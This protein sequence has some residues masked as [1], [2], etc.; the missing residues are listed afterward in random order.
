MFLLEKFYEKVDRKIPDNRVGMVEPSDLRAVIKDLGFQLFSDLKS[1]TAGWSPVFAV[2]PDGERRV[3]K[4]VDWTGSLGTK[5]LTGLYVGETGL[6]ED[7]AQ[8]VDV[9]GVAGLDGMDGSDG[10][11][12]TPGAPGPK[13]WSPILAA[14]ADGTRRVMQVVDWVGGEGAKPATGQFLTPTGLTTVL[15]NALDMRGAPGADGVNGTPGALWFNGSGVP[16]T[17]TGSNGDYFLNTASGD[18]YRKQSGAW[19]LQ[20]NIR[21]PQGTSGTPGTN[22]TNG[23]TWFNSTGVPS[24][25]TGADGDYHLNTST[26]DVSRKAA[27]AWSVI[28]NIR[29]PQGTPGTN[30]TNGAT[31]FSGSGVPA[32]ATG[33]N[34]DHYLNTV[35]G[36]VYRRQSGAW[37]VVGNI[38]GADGVA[39]AA[40]YNG[41]G[42]PSNVTGVNG[43]YYLDTVSGDVYRKT[44][45]TWGIVGNIKGPGGGGGGATEPVT[46]SIGASGASTPTFTGTLTLIGFVTVTPGSITDRVKLSGW[47]RPRKD[48]GTTVRQYWIQCKRNLTGAA[49]ASSD[50]NIG[51]SDSG[52]FSLGTANSDMSVAPFDIT[53]APGVATPVTYSLWA[54]SDGSTLTARNY[55]INAQVLTG[56]SGGGSS[57]GPASVSVASASFTLAA[58]DGG[59]IIPVTASIPTVITVPANASVSIPAGTT[60]HLIQESTGFV[61]VNP[62]SGVTLRSRNDYRRTA[63]RGDRLTLTKIDTNVWDLSGDLAAPLDGFSLNMAY[64]FSMRRLFSGYSHK[65]L[66]IRRNGDNQETGV[67]FDSMGRISR[68]SPTESDRLTLAEWAGWS[69][70]FVKEFYNQARWSHYFGQYD[71]NM[72]PKM[73]FDASGRAMLRFDGQD[74]MG[75]GGGADFRFLHDGTGCFLRLKYSNAQTTLNGAAVRVLLSTTEGGYS[76][77]TGFAIRLNADNQRSIS[78]VRGSSGNLLA[79]RDAPATSG[80]EI[81]E[82]RHK[83]DQNPQAV[84]NLNGSIYSGAYSSA[85]PSSGDS[86]FG[87]FLGG[88]Y[89]FQASA[90]D[91]DELIIFREMLSDNQVIAT[92]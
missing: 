53:D 80:Y 15:A 50:P 89:W 40:W 75:M 27:G 61:V 2:V 70:V 69:D 73:V 81:A 41:T 88:P 91:F 54:R 42:A 32:S 4:L 79:Y 26:G 44:A 34:G 33:V 29:G 51:Q 52:G 31:W 66:H 30:G 48:G 20:G 59:K 38:R 16:A 67:F 24:A 72:Q 55:E 7:M 3:M 92:L 85:P 21:G 65:V 8:A 14:V 87:M 76:G 28:G 78:I 10:L 77:E 22:G 90:F 68:F 19:S 17:A 9:R 36:D 62:A 39:G 12:G 57:S 86:P 23:A 64:A 74:A 71:W 11:P 47:L 83:F 1:A 35:N 25:A 82:F 58:S 45:G 46:Q 60:V 63:C 18:V 56:S 84:L 6:V 43:D 37:S 13:G 5:P 49:P